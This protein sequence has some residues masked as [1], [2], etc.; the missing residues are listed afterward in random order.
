[1]AGGLGLLVGRQALAEGRAGAVTGPA[2]DRSRWNA[3]DPALRKA[4]Q[5]G[6]SALEA[7]DVAEE[8]KLLTQLIGQ[9]DGAQYRGREWYGDILGRAYGDRGNARARQGKLKAALGDYDASIERA[10][11]AADPVL[12]K[13]VALEAMGDFPGAIECYEEVLEA[14]P[15][16]PAGW[17]NL[18][19]AKLGMGDWS[20]AARGYDEAARLAPQFSFSRCNYAIALYQGAEDDAAVTKT[21]QSLT[22]KYPNFDDPHAAL[23]AI[24]WDAGERGK[25]ED[26]WLRVEDPRYGDIAWLVKERRWPTRLTAAMA[27][28]IAKA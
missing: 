21:L 7:R 26:E 20:G 11:W 5:L 2:P 25:A 14:N 19:N 15:S 17:N 23:T 12:N 6:Q 3:R 27:R 18:G 24:L 9:F 16:D 13:G 1:M 28:F 8:E 4:A 22:R 10:P